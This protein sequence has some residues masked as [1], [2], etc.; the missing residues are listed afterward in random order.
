MEKSNLPDIVSQ[1]ADDLLEKA[2]EEDLVH[3]LLSLLP[4]GGFLDKFLFRRIRKHARQRLE[5]FHIKFAEQLS[6][7]DDQKVDKEFLESEEFDTLVM[8]IVS[9]AYSSEVDHLFRL[10]PSS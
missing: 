9:N 10:I 2:D 3:G 8:K 6:N 5:E 7:L 4:A 1:K